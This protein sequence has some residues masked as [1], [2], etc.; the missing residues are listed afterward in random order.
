M[1]ISLYKTVLK[2]IATEKEVMKGSNIL[3]ISIICCLLLVVESHGHSKDKKHSEKCT[4]TDEQK[5]TL[6]KTEKDGAV[7]CKEGVTV[8]CYKIGK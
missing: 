3:L 5:I 2:D 7:L 8:Y 1:L 4:N 6:I